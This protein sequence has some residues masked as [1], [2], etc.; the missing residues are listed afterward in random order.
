MHHTLGF[1][2][3]QR[4]FVVSNE[5]NF[6]YNNKCHNKYGTSLMKTIKGGY[7]RA[8]E[9]TNL[10]KWGLYFGIFYQICF[11]CGGIFGSIQGR[12]NW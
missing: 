12:T 6:T 2:F 3:P 10:L 11:F 5:D 8:L 9:W 4:Q 1:V 7:I